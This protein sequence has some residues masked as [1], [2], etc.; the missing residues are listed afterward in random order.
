MTPILGFAPDVQQTTIGVLNDCENLIPYKNGMEGAPT[1]VIP[2][3]IQP[4]PEPVTGAVIAYQ[5]DDTQRFLAGTE[6]GLYELVSGEWDNVTYDGGD[7]GDWYFAQFGEDTLASNAAEAIWR[8]TGAEFELIG[9]APIAEIIFS[10]G[11]F[12][13]ALNVNDGATKPDGWHCCAAFDATD[14]DEDVATQCASGLLVDTQGSI[15]A[16]ARL[17]EYAIAYKQWSIYL[18]QYVGAPEVWRWKLVPG[19]DAGCVG[20]RAL[21]DI[22]GSHFFVG[23]DNFWI[24]NGAQAIPVGEGEVRDWFNEEVDKS[25]MSV[26]RC[27]WDR[28]R[29]LVWI[30]YPT[31]GSEVCDA[32]LVYHPSTKRWGKVNV[33]VQA[34]VEYVSVG[35][36]FDTWDEAGETFDTLPDIPFNSP[37]WRSDARALAV[38][39]LDN[40]LQTLDGES[41]TSSLETCE[42]GDDDIYTLLTEFRMRFEVAPESATLQTLYSE[43][44]GNDF[45]VGDTCEI[46]D[47]KFDPLQSARLHKGI[48]SFEGP[49]RIT[50]MNAKTKPDG[51]R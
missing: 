21:C 31:A 41:E 5:P 9:G 36:T 13:M 33:G 47:G 45:T 18:G 29:K 23:R 25:F 46:N 20:K 30:F 27:I 6:E 43:N 28:Q 3:G 44:S 1:P 48:V 49:V 51:E 11:S 37:F 42:I 24:F 14:W 16:G 17:G 50:H 19:A 34:A 15:T 35:F 39:N 38:F 26:I 8:S 2:D 7:G 12:V 10:V 32:A 4:L 22:G 40:Q